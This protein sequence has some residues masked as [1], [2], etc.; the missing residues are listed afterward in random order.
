MVTLKQV[1]CNIKTCSSNHQV[2]LIWLKKRKSMRT[3]LGNYGQNVWN[4]RFENSQFEKNTKK[5]V[6]T[7]VV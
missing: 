2:N 1:R 7:N 4:W 5:L 3:I 6:P